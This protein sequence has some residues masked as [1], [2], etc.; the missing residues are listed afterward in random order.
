[1]TE[2]NVGRIL[3]KII[4][5]IC[6]GLIIGFGIVWWKWALAII[7]GIFAVITLIVHHKQNSEIEYD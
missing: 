2:Y 6:L 4:F 7:I 5:A 1:M 3:G